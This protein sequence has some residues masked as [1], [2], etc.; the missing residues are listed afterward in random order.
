M[1]AGKWFAGC[2]TMSN[3]MPEIERKF[4]VHD[5]PDGLDHG[6]RLRQAYLAV[7]GDVEVRV[8]DS[9]GTF[10]LGVKGGRGLER[11]EV[12]RE[13]DAATFDELW[14][15][16]EARRID[17]IRYRVPTGGHTAEV[18]VYSGSLAGLVVAEVEFP[19]RQEAEEF[20]PPAWFGDELTGDPR[21]S[22]AGLASHGTPE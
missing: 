1:H 11:T 13:I 17:K 21:W 8:R 16:A 10:V 19:S 14:R 4:R 6:T 2:E 15:L 3:R 20:S 5:V 9:A 7:D 12:E 22:N 18:D